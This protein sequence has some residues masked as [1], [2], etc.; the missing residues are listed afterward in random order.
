[1]NASKNYRFKMLIIQSIVF[2][3]LIVA[4]DIDSNYTGIILPLSASWKVIFITVMVAGLFS[5]L[6]IPF[7][8]FGLSIVWNKV[9]KIKKEK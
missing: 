9:I 5:W 1:M 6:M 2:F 7:I 8:V 3:I 4:I